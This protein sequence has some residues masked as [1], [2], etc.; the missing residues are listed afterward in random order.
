MSEPKITHVESEPLSHLISHGSLIL[1]SAILAVV[2]LANILERWVLPRAYGALWA[3]LSLGHNDRRRR[4]F[5]YLHIGVIVMSCLVILGCYPVFNFLV[6]H[7]RPSSGLLGHR[8]SHV[9]HGDAMFVLSQIYSAY[10]LFELSY[11]TQFASAIGIAH[12]IG[13]LLVIQSALALFG[14]L[15]KHPEAILEFYMCMVWGELS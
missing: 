4:S 13:L 1:C 10:Y 6:G 7:A 11:R 9:S 12:H 3:D 8:H 2:I 14:N 15:E 5:T